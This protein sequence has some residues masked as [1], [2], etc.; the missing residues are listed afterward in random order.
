MGWA[1]PERKQSKSQRYAGAIPTIFSRP[2]VEAGSGSTDRADGPWS[3]KP[4]PTVEEP[5][6]SAGPGE[7]ARDSKLGGSPW[8]GWYEAKKL[9]TWSTRAVSGP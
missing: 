5:P 2:V 6:R 8:S 4:L 9:A 1:W 3:K 7:S